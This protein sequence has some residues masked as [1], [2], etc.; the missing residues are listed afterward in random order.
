MSCPYH[1]PWHTS[2]ERPRYAVIGPYILL[3]TP[4]VWQATVHNHEQ[5]YLMYL[6]FRFRPYTCLIYNSDMKSDSFIS[7]HRAFLLFPSLLDL[8]LCNMNPS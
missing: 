6:I 1:P 3:S 7:R 8:S 2:Y 5:V 4:F